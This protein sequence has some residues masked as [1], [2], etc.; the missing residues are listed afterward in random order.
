M[1]IKERLQFIVDN[2]FGGNKAAF[3]EA[4]GLRPTTISNYIGR[5]DRTSKP[6]SDILENI[7]NSVSGINTFWLL[8]GEGD[9]F[10]DGES[11]QSPHVSLISGVPYYDDIEATGSILS[12]NMGTPE[13]PTF[14]INYEHF[15]D[16]TAY[17]PVVGSSMHP[18]YCSGEI[19]AVK[20][21]FNMSIIQWGEAYLVVTNDSANSLRTIKLVFPHKDENKIILRA[22]NPEYIGDTTID[23]KDILSMFIVK[24]KITRNQL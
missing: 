23:K 22:C 6:S 9:P 15:N 19:V 8:T 1:N 14:Y 21:I 10:G 5:G 4:V 7:V 17:V 3:A 11:A 2:K 12:I 13:I 24:G 16:C 18:Y 20:R